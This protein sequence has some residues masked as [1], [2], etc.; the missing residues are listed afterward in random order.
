M[1]DKSATKSFAGATRIGR[2]EH[3]LFGA[4]SACVVNQ[5]IGGKACAK[6]LR[7]RW[8]R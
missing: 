5:I 2:C 3:I 8:L 7:I 4:Q 6:A 1:F